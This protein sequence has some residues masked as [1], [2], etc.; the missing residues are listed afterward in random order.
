MAEMEKQ[1]TDLL[2]KGYITPSS[3]PYGAPVL[4]VKKLRSAELRMCVDFRA[5]NALT[6][7]NSGPLPR[8]DDML[9]QLSSAKVFSAIDLRSAYNQVQLMLLQHFSQS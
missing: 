4:F 2:A 8:I 6:V 5:L 1:V 9:A 3:S 7:R